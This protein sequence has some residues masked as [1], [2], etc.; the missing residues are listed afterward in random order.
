[1]Y[2][3][4]TTEIKEDINKYRDIFYSWTGRL[5]MVKMSIFPKMIYRFN[6]IPIKFPARFFVH[7]DKII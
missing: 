4:L 5:N 6:I 2:T 7:I 3:A 1:M